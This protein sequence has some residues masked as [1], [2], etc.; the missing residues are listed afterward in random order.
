M[1]NKNKIIEIL[2]P[3][4]RLASTEN[5]PLAVTMSLENKVV[6]FLDNGKPNFNLFLDRLEGVMLN[7]YQVS[8]V[9][10]YRK[11]F[12]ATSAGP[13]LLEELSQNCDLVITGSCD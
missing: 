3:T 2:T 8:N 10:R 7:D 12:A 5:K 13:Q 11:G 9:L 1:S 6:G 4:G